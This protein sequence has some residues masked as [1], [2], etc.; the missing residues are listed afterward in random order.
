MP[1]GDF[2]NII[3]S[4]GGLNDRKMGGGGPEVN[5]GAIKISSFNHNSVDEVSDAS[6][7]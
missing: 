3:R 1:A 7:G 4:G 6:M 5:K 2:D